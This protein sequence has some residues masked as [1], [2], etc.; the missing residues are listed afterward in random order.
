MSFIERFIT[1]RV[2]YQR[3]DCIHHRHILCTALVVYYRYIVLDLSIAYKIIHILQQ[4]NN[5]DVYVMSVL[6]YA[7]EIHSLKLLFIVSK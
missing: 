1:G 2:H 3:F 7:P 6:Y 4:W 5:T